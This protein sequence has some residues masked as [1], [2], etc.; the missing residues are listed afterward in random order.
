MEN[1]RLATDFSSASPTT[2]PQIAQEREFPRSDQ[3]LFTD[4]N[5]SV[6]FMP[7]WR[8]GAAVVPICAELSSVQTQPAEARTGSTLKRS[9][10]LPAEEW[11]RVPGRREWP[12]RQSPHSA[13]C[14]PIGACGSRLG[15][16][17]PLPDPV[18]PRTVPRTVPE[19]AA[20]AS[21]C[22]SRAVQEERRTCSSSKP[23]TGMIRCSWA[24]RFTRKPSRPSRRRVAQSTLPVAA[25]MT[26]LRIKS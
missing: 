13:G 25:Q 26:P 21:S 1:R 22:C 3:R 19:H 16:V 2:L 10:R 9:S 5:S 7:R 11:P 4:P 6:A 24:A 23:V 12:A 14:G 8:A 20:T 17:G 18:R 15:G